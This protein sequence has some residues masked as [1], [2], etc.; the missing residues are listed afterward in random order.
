M[1]EKVSLFS[2]DAYKVKIDNWSEEHKDRILDL[3]SDEW[4]NDHYTDF[5]RHNNGEI[6]P[7]ANELLQILN[8]YLEEFFSKNQISRITSLWCQRCRSGDFHGPHD[9]GSFG[10]SA[11]FYAN[12]DIGVHSGT[13]FF[14]PFPNDH[15]QKE[16]IIVSVQEGDLI[17]FPSH[18]LHMGTLHYD[19]NKERVIFSF[20]F[21]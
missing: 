13:Q 20:N 21:L 16:N 11:V 4:W 8:P 15:G 10:Y 9:H 2:I 12:M 7:Y 1:F 5:H 17:I 3:V 19:P 6:P 14:C 18:V